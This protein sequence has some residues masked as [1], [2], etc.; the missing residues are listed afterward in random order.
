MGNDRLG[1]EHCIQ[2]SLTDFVTV[3]NFLESTLVR[4]FRHGR[5]C[6]LDKV[7]SGC[8]RPGFVH[9][10]VFVLLHRIHEACSPPFLLYYL[11]LAA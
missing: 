5:H 8:S 1:S 10:A 7:V 2:I 11:L 9:N 4:I 6:D 3:E